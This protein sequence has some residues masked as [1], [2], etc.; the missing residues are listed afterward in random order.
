LIKGET[1]ADN[2]LPLLRLPLYGLLCLAMVTIT[3]REKD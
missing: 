2:L 3:L 1:L